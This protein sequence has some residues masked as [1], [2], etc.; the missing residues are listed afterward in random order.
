MKPE[1]FKGLMD[2]IKC[3][4]KQANLL[5][6]S[7]PDLWTD[8]KSISRSSTSRVVQSQWADRL[9]DFVIPEST[10]DLFNKTSATAKAMIEPSLKFTEEEMRANHMFLSVEQVGQL[11]EVA[12]FMVTEWLLKLKGPSE[13]SSDGRVRIGPARLAANVSGLFSDGSF[14]YLALIAFLV[15]VEATGGARTSLYSMLMLYMIW[16]RQNPSS[17]FVPL[18]HLV[19]TRRV[20][21]PRTPTWLT[22]EYLASD[23]AIEIQVRLQIRYGEKRERTPEGERD[24]VSCRISF[25][26][27]VLFECMSSKLYALCVHVLQV[28]PGLPLKTHCDDVHNMNNNLNHDTCR[29]GDSGW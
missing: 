4:L 2:R 25:H 9:S 13:S 21:Q 3:V 19:L 10:V 20:G 11:L 27:V 14:G 29:Y 12:T 5:F 26:L 22:M 17:P 15:V 24:V 16:V 28:I 6:L 18:W 1:T 23:A 7:R 8:D